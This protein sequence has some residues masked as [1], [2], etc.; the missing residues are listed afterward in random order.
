MQQGDGGFTKPHPNTIG[1]WLGAHKQRNGSEN[2]QQTR[3]HHL[4]HLLF[5]AGCGILKNPNDVLRE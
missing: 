4:E 3:T 2:S 1:G 5:C